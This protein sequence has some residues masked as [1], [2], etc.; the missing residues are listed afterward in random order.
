MYRSSICNTWMVSCKSLHDV[1]SRDLSH[2]HWGCWRR[3]PPQRPACWQMLMHGWAMWWML[4][5]LV[6]VTQA[7]ALLPCRICQSRRMMRRVITD[8]E[9]VALHAVV[10]WCSTWIHGDW[11]H[12]GLLFMFDHAW[13]ACTLSMDF[14]CH[15]LPPRWVL[16]YW[17]QIP[18]NR[19]VGWDTRTMH[20][21][22]FSDC[23]R[24]SHYRTTFCFWNFELADIDFQA[25][26]GGAPIG[27]S[28]IGNSKARGK[29]S[30]NWCSDILATMDFWALPA[31][32]WGDDE[33]RFFEAV[34]ED[35]ERLQAAC[36]WCEQSLAKNVEKP[37]IFS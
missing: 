15:I 23:R 16:W 8:A 2:G 14:N 21:K 5:D 32:R 31:S 20:L 11:L 3:N 4:M 25:G 9:G 36:G 28:T 1:S 33:G 27:A 18:I 10:L 37:A 35:L 24:K 29:N 30:K 17:V 13:Y 7:Q 12:A 22:V 6:G 26:A 34:W 19:N